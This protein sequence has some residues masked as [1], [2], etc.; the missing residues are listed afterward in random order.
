MS[1]MRSRRVLVIAVVAFV[2]GL[3][4]M[5]VVMRKQAGPRS[6]STDAS[7]VADAAA[8]TELSV[9]PVTDVR[10]AATTS[11]TADT[12]ARTKALYRCV[13]AKSGPVSYTH[14]RAH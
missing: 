3:G 14:L 12:L 11:H 6:Q 13:A 10:E 4:V 1:A 8:V 2:L 5:V 9:Q 7:L